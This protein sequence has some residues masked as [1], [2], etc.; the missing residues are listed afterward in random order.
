MAARAA[1]FTELPL[2]VGYGRSHH[3]VTSNHAARN[4]QG[5]LEERDGGDVRPR[6]LIDN[7][8]AVRVN[9]NAEP[10]LR[11]DAVMLVESVVGELAE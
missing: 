5:R 11:L 2:S 4:R 10:L 1:D 6:Q 7:S 9:V 3:R 8:V